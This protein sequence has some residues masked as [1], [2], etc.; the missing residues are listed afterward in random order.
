V[1]WP[2][3]A[4]IAGVA[5]AGILSLIALSNA[6]QG[7]SDVVQSDASPPPV[8]LT[9]PRG[10]TGD[11]IAADR[12][13]AEHESSVD[14]FPY[15]GTGPSGIDG[16]PDLT[17]THLVEARSGYLF[18]LAPLLRDDGFC[19]LT[20]PAGSD[21]SAMWSWTCATREEFA[22]S[23]LFTSMGRAGLFWDGSRFEVIDSSIT[24]ETCVGDD[25]T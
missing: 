22:L 21:E 8:P 9:G 1:L 19:M 25:R 15:A 10:G 14:P 24:C 17:R 16:E 18:W 12:W 23:G 5:V 2:V 20:T 11:L 7:V 3:L 13:F 6:R 4:F